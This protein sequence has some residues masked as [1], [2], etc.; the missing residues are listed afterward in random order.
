M[1]PVGYSNGEATRIF[2]RRLTGALPEVSRYSVASVLALVF[3]FWAYLELV[4]AGVAA[5]LAG[6]SGYALGLTLHFVL[7]TRFVFRNSREEKPNARL[8]AEFVMTGLL[9]LALT[10]GI[11][12]VATMAMGV[13]P[14]PAKLL[15]VGVSF[16]AV[17]A[18]RRSMVFAKAPARRVEMAGVSR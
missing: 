10:A 4:S 3:D 18:V 12:A 5:T 1:T 8:F 14:L 16:F 6:I 7:S 9:G 2:L 11:I 15:A 13:S 17:F